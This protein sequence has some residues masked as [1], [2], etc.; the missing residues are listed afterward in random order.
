MHT[1]GEDRLWNRPFLQLSDLRDH[2]HGSASHGKL[3][4]STHRPLPTYKIL[5]KLEQLFV[6][7]RTCGHWDQPAV[8]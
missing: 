4:C 5:F 3:S 1:G 2:D 6:D 7:R 8:L